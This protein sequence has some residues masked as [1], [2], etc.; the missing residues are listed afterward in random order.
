MITLSH[1]TLNMLSGIETTLII[2]IVSLMIGFINACCI[3]YLLLSKKTIS[4]KLV[5]GYYKIIKGTPLLLQLF[6]VYYGLGSINY[7]QHSVFWVLLKHP[8]ACAILVLS[9]NS[10]AFVSSLIT[11]AINKI[12]KQQTSCAKTLGFTDLQ[13][14]INI[15]LPLAI[16]KICAY[17]HNEILTLLKSS[18]LASTIACL[19][20]SGAI[21]QIVSQNFQNLKWYCILALINILLG[22]MLF[23]TFKKLLPVT[24]T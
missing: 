5:A 24:K 10:S 2:T 22:G 17:Y 15:Q 1:N 3:S 23:V 11:G 18:S 20:I 4:G 9:N 7:V 14:Y 8:M 16:K 13:I 19:D 6:F 12:P 21:S